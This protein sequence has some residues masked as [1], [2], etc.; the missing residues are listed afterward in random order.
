MIEDLL[1]KISKLI[2]DD[3]FKPVM[4]A[5]EIFVTVLAVLIFIRIFKAINHKI[6]VNLEKK[7]KGIHIAFFRNLLDIVITVVVIILGISSFAGAKSLWTTVLGGTS[8]LIAVLTFA[9]Q[10]VIKD[11]IAGIILSIY[12]PFDIGDRIELDNG[13]AGVVEDINMRHV[14]LVTIDSLRE[15]IPNSKI[16]NMYIINCSYGL[17]LKSVQMK[18]NIGYDSDVA[19]AKKLVYETIEKSD[20]TVPGRKGKD[21]KR[22]Y[23]PVY[24]LNYAESSLVLAVTVYYSKIPTEVVKDEINTKI[25]ETFRAH[26]IEIPYNYVNVVNKS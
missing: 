25:N 26:G 7:K 23:S 10:D 5:L 21:G 3:A 19:L 6:F 12:K 20:K 24:F 8:V 14:V 9:A 11:V 1:N 4:I 18:F 2:S 16:N 22:H 13:T 15:I 17:D